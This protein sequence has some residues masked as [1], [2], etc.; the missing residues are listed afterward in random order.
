MNIYQFE[1]YR[2]Y[3]NSWVK[4]QPK[5][6]RGEYRKLAVQLGV[7]STMVSQ[8]FK[9]DKNLN[10]ELGLE[11]SEFLGLE[12]KEED[13][14]LL[15]IDYARA[16]SFK[17]KQKLL[18]NINDRQEKAKILGNQLKK[19]KVLT[20]EVIAQYYSNWPYTGIRNLTALKKINSVDDISSYLNI[21]RA[22]VK[23]VVDFLLKNE[24]C[25]YDENKKIVP[26]PQNTHLPAESF[27]VNF[28]HQN[29]R[30]QGIQKMK[31]KKSDDLFYSCPMSLSK[32]TA[33]KIRK[34]L[35]HFLKKIND[36]VSPSKSEVVR[37]LNF[38][39]FSY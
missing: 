31:Q 13:Y 27:M 35:P 23:R 38:D 14:F 8:V 33:E 16:G 32:K 11:V 15:L 12:D 4:T 1:D 3:F 18:K 10:P 19:D 5:A 6:G 25:L 30:M 39:W 2:L 20:Q 21:P 26:G 22:Q 37:C 17:L 34:E 7:S 36:W 28:H 9:G 24:L 29:W